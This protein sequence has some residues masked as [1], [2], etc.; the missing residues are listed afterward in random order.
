MGNAQ[1]AATIAAEVL[2]AAV[3]QA[4]EE[5]WCMREPKITK[6]CGGYSADAE[7]ILRSWW[8]D[9]LANIQDRELDNKAAIQLIKEQTL[10]NAH[11]EVEFQ[12]DLCGGEISYQ[13]LLRHLSVTFQGDNDEANFLAEFYSHAQK[14]KESEEAFADELQIF[15]RKVVIKK[16]DFWVHLDS[17]LKQ[18]YASQLYDHKS[19]SIMKTLLVQM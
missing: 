11:R 7:L 18:C 6:L 8:V 12:L 1:D 14:V 2:T 16:L 17:T 19:T 10:E 4:S 5:F 15:M 9:M 3:A 13:D